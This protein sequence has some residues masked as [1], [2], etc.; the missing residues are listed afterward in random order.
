MALAEPF[1]HWYHEDN[2]FASRERMEFVHAPIV[3]A[4]VDALA[5]AGG[6][7]LD[8]GC[9]NAALLRRIHQAAPGIVPFGVERV[10]DSVAHARA[11]LPGFASNLLEGDLFEAETLWDPELRF[12]LAL[13]SPRRLLEVRPEQ[14]S[15]LREWLRLRCDALLV[16]AYG[17]GLTEFGDLAGFAHQAGIRLAN[18]RSGD[19]AC[20][21]AAF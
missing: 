5:G 6:N 17:T 20:L 4:A 14:A 15:R 18:P 11:L 16:Y 1:P 8:L 19:R 10:A 3:A 2:R 13:L 21:A 12:S 9:G 7:V